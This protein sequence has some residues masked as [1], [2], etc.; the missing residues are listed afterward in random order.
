MP[1]P[2]PECRRAVQANLLLFGA[3]AEALLARVWSLPSV[4]DSGQTAQ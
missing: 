4:K 2:A 1:E 3:I